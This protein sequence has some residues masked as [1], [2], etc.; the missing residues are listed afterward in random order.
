MISAK[1]HSLRY[2]DE[3]LKTGQ[4]LG[5][6][7]RERFGIKDMQAISREVVDSFIQEKI[8]QK[9]TYGTIS[10]Y[11]SI[12]AKLQIGLEAIEAKIPEHHHLYSREDLKEIREPGNMQS[13]ASKGPE[14]ISRLKKSLEA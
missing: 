10:N 8:V 11:I 1:V 12:M 5:N 7:A 14:T 13:K 2:K 6:F 9:V 4:A 3:I